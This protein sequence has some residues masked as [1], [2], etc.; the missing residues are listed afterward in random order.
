LNLAAAA[1]AE[2]NHF[3]LSKHVVS[4]NNDGYER[5]IASE[6]KKEEMFDCSEKET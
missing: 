2:P 1:A 6:R 4:Y 5:K 3:L